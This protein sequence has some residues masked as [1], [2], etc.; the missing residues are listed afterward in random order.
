LNQPA[1]PMDFRRQLLEDVL[2]F[3]EAH[4]IDERNGGYWT[5]L[6]RDGSRYGRGDRYLVMQ[7]RMIYSFCTG[8]RLSGDPR[9]LEL[10]RR[11]VESFTAAFRDERRGG[12]F[13]RTDRDGAPIE[14]AKRPY[15]LAFAVYALAEYARLSGD[16]RS[17]TDAR[18]TWDLLERH[19]WD[20]DRGGFYHELG[21][22]WTPVTTTKRIDTMLHNM[23]GVSAL[24]AATGEERYLAAIRMICDTIMRRTWDDAHRCT[25]EWF[26]QD[27]REDLTNTGGK[28][29]YGHIAETAWFLASV[30]AFTG[31]SAYVDFARAELDYA[32]RFGWDGEHGGLFAHGTPDGQVTDTTKV[33][34]MQSELLDALAIFHRLT[35]EER[36]LDHL[37]RLAVYLERGQRDPLF[38]EWYSRCRADGTP[39]DARKGSEWKAAY[40][41]V[42]GLYQ[43]DRHLAA[44]RAN[45]PRAPAWSEW[46][47]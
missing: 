17:L 1:D 11:G 16:Q 23:E 13:F 42:Q 2:P 7:T 29:N 19:A 39:L 12:W 5:T 21:E 37:R 34:W 47:L 22:D 43:A 3:W 31:S 6:H 30:G 9:H 40:H 8:Y 10:A 41:V 45:E 36:Y 14:T 27:W 38:G 46:A 25:H 28:T 18:E 26:Y 33:W 44:A 35:G 20:H 4:G 24:Y 32:L 15:G